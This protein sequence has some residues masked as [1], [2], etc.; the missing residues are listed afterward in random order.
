MDARSDIFA[1]G[2]SLYE[3]LTGKHPS[4]AGRLTRTLAAL[5][6]D[7]PEP[8]TRLVPALPPEA[9]RAVLRCL[10]KD[11]H[12]L[13]EHLRS[14]RGAGGREGG[15]GVGPNGPNSIAKDGARP[16][17]TLSRWPPPGPGRGRHRGPPAR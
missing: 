3:M 1:F 12:A 7:D 4:A 2:L 5:R 10:R 16:P 8:P 14:R 13:A 17:W 11:P 15:L 9:E 6:E